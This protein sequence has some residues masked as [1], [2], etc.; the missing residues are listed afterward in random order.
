LIAHTIAALIFVKYATFVMDSN[1][2]VG[3]GLK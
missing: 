3:I 1:I 2:T